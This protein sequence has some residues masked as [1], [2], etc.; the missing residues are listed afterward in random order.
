MK[1]QPHPAGSLVLYAD[2]PADAPDYGLVLWV[3]PNATDHWT[4][5][6]VFGF[7]EYLETDLYSVDQL[8]AP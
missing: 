1:T 6:V 4:H 7:G 8:V 2:S 3:D 5:L